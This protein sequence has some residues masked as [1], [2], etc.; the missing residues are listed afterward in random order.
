MTFRS[1]L[2]VALAC[3]AA[4]PALA[5]SQRISGDVVGLDG[6]TLT[7]RTANGTSTLRVPADARIS[8][9]FPV[10]WSTI[11]PGAYVATT[12]VPQP[13]GTLLAKEIR[14][15]EESQRGQGE[16]HY[17]MSTPG[18]TMTNATVKDLSHG[19]APARDTM[20][21]AT[22]ATAAKS[23][24]GHRLTLT[25]KGGEQTVVVPDDVPLVRSAPG[26]VALLKP[27]THVVVYPRTDNDGAQVVQ[28]I[29]VGRNG[30]VPPV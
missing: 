29:S 1:M 27:G 20:T 17:P 11:G 9:R 3:L 23:G 7:V 13:D 22:V 8:V 16:G 19:A 26:D 12:A 15:F 5:Q 24:G 21:N 25:Y 14:V 6:T 2:V 10:D 30:F 4:A 18:D 28:R